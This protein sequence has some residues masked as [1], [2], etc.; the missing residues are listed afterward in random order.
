MHRIITLLFLILL[1]IH[2]SYSQGASKL[3]GTWIRYSDQ[4]IAEIFI[5]RANGEFLAN[6]FT[7]DNQLRNIE[8]GTWK[9]KGDS[10]FF[11]FNQV[12]TSTNSKNWN[13]VNADQLKPVACKFLFAQNGTL[14]IAANVYQRE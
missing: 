12:I 2:E 3:T 1:P 14:K 8:K 5:I 9:T 7:K 13:A 4:K 6:E 11:Y 10:I